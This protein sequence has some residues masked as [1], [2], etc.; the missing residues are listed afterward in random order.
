MQLFSLLLPLLQ[1]R[2][3]LDETTDGAL[4]ETQIGCPKPG[5]P[6]AEKGRNIVFKIGLL[7]STAMTAVTLLLSGAVPPR[8]VFCRHSRRVQRLN[9]SAKNQ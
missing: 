5:A 6:R 4:P 1:F 2:I 9:N 8:R 3:T 7:T